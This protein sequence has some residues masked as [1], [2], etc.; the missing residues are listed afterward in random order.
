MQNDLNNLGEKKKKNQ[1]TIRRMTID[2][3]AP[4]F[5]LGEELF[6]MEVSPNLYRTW[7]EYE[8][9]SNFQNDQEYCFVAEDADSDEI[10]GFLMGTIIAK[11]HS[12][13]RYGYLIWLGI[14]PSFQ[15]KGV[16]SKLFHHFRHLMI[17]NGVRM[18]LVDTA[19]DNM[20]ALQFFEKM[21]F[22]KPKKHIYLSLN[23]DSTHTL[24]KEKEKKKNHKE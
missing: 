16:A 21:G 7:D 11:R 14:T 3:I 9:I 2:D 12:S 20:P 8:V 24:H 6:T 10:A 4:V 5:H 18:L 1:I 19:A 23:L 17:K 15:S 22:E 13:W